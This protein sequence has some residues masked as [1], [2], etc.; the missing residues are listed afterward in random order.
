[1]NEDVLLAFR[2]YTLAA[3]TFTR[4]LASS[5]VTIEEV[6][7]A[8]DQEERKTFEAIDARIAELKGELGQ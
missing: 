3:Q 4:A 6:K 7:A 2:L 1:M 5:G 8:V